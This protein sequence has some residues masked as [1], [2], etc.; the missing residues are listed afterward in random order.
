MATTPPPLLL[1][2]SILRHIHPSSLRPSRY[3]P[4]SHVV[5]TQTNHLH[6]QG[7][8]MLTQ[9]ESRRSSRAVT[10]TRTLELGVVDAARERASELQFG[11]RV[12]LNNPSSPLL[13]CQL[14]LLL[15]LLLQVPP[16]RVAVHEG[17]WFFTATWPD[18]VRRHT[19]W[20][21]LSWLQD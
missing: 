5:M 10:R 7:P 15:W 21:Q 20:Q 11:R 2:P 13:P 9:R 18:E 6:C 17:R 8:R 3:V 19:S 14:L 4:V 12:S 1:P 16:T